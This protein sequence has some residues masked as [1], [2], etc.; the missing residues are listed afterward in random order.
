ML[1]WP[2]VLAIF[3]NVIIPVVLVAVLGMA[4]HRWKRPATAPV[5]LLV[6]NLFS[7]A[8]VFVS[9]A[10]SD[11]GG[12]LFARTTIFVVLLAI[13]SLS[14]AWA[15]ARA[16]RADR[17]T[18]SGMLLGSAFMNVNN[19]GLPVTQFAFGQAALERAVLF[20]VTQAI[21]TW[22][23]GAY[24]AARSS[25]LGLRPLLGAFRLPTTYAA[26]AGVLI[27]LTGA[28]VPSPI[29][30]PLELLALAAIPT[31][32]V[33]LGFQLS[34]GALRQ[35]GTVAVVV[36][37]RLVLSAAIAFPLSLWVGAQGLD[38]QVMIVMAAMPTAVFTSLLA[39]EFGANPTLV[40]SV[41]VTSS[42]ASIV[43]LAVVIRLVQGLA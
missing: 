8:L 28:H 27:S 14:M 23:L 16:I 11:L 30:K 31:M 25:T 1:E 29:M 40:S 39:T 9:L 22:T 12:A 4:L 6:L 5:S 42:V 7:P 43:T 35:P 15:V 10:K 21:L 36:L 17:H 18:E 19:L 32:L 37:L 24:I 20:F 26:M 3:V 33:V 13:A 2:L 41:V 34:T 38:R